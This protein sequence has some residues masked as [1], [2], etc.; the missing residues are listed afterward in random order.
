M[1]SF[2]RFNWLKIL[3]NKGERSLRVFNY[4]HYKLFS[5]DLVLIFYKICLKESHNNAGFQILILEFY[6]PVILVKII[7][8]FLLCALRFLIIPCHKTPKETFLVFPFKELDTWNLTLFSF[9]FQDWILSIKIHS[10]YEK[11]L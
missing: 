10:I 2:Q 1:E 6:R 4:K 9:I 7:L 5:P 3:L 11:Y 8:I